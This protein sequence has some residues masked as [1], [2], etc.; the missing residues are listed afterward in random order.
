MDIQT[1]DQK[2]QTD[3][4]LPQHLINVNQNEDLAQIQ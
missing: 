1:N 3:T 4:T 2:L